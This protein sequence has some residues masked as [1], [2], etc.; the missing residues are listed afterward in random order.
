[1]STFA[2]CFI[3]LHG[4]QSSKAVRWKQNRIGN[5][6]SAA[7]EEHSSFMQFKL[8]IINVDGI[9]IRINGYELECNC[10]YI[11]NLI[12]DAHKFLVL[13]DLHPQHISAR[14]EQTSP[15]QLI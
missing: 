3:I 14:M 6:S 15:R 4:D 10:K 8:T 11:Q 2:T 12:Y 1:M 13:S 7:S 5:V 9:M